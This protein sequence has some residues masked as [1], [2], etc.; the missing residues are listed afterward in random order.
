MLKVRTLTL[1]TLERRKK[2]LRKTIFA[3][4]VTSLF[5]AYAVAADV[6]SVEKSVQ[7]EA[8]NSDSLMTVAFT[9]ANSRHVYKNSAKKSPGK[10]K[11]RNNNKQKTG[12]VELY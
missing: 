1:I 9:R 2:M 4:A 10:A 3:I 11:R 5:S 6:A 12:A 8:A 7:S